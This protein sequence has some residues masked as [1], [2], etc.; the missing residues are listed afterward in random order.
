MRVHQ[1][2][3]S[4]Q[5]IQ[6]QQAFQADRVQPRDTVPVNPLEDLAVS[7][8]DIS[9]Q[10]TAGLNTDAYLE[11]RNIA[12]QAGYLDVPDEAIRQAYAFGGSLLTDYRI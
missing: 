8:P 2:L 1:G 3:S 12:R 9:A 11:I 10:Q 5:M 6:A 4:I 7:R